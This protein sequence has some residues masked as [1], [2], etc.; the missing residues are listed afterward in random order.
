MKEF[1]KHP[2][3]MKSAR[4]VWY[5]DVNG[6]RYLDGISGIFV[7]N[8][9]HGNQKIIDAMKKQLD[10]LTFAP[11]LLSTNVRALQLTELISSLTPG[12]LHTV[13]C[14]AVAQKLPRP[15]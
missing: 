13:S 4:G 5:E 8:A 7:V 14:S 1:V 15:R 11:P 3:I 12:N 10:E 2:L 6:K 9:G